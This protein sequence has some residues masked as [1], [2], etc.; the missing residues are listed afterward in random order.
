M[1]DFTEEYG[2]CPD[3]DV[4]IIQMEASALGRPGVGS[5]QIFPFIIRILT[6]RQWGHQFAFGAG[7]QLH[8]R[9]RPH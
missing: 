3:R 4:S 6:A 9:Q 2:V 8:C 7:P 5:C 1:A